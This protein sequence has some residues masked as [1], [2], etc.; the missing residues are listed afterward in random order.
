MTKNSKSNG[1][2]ITAHTIMA[3]MRW[4]IDRLPFGQKAFSANSGLWEDK[5][6]KELEHL[7]EYVPKNLNF[8]LII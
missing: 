6:K 5:D 1:I 2:I 3:R 7:N 8:S 4:T